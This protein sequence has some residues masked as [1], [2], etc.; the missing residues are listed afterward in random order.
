M[1][2]MPVET[3][4]KATHVKTGNFLAHKDL[5]NYEELTRV[6][7]LAVALGMT[8]IRLTGGEPLVRR[9]VISFIE[10]LAGIDG[11]EQVRLTTNGVLLN[12]YAERLYDA[13]VKHI[14]ISLDTLQRE[15]FNR[16]TGK[17]Y[18]DKVWAGIM[19]A[20]DLGFNVKLNTVAMRNINDDEFKEFGEL[21]LNHP[22]Q[23]RFIEFM[24]VGEKSSWEKKQFIKSDE[25]KEMI[26]SLGTLTPF[27]RKHGEGPARMYDL[28]SNDGRTGS[29][30]F[31]SPISHHFCDKCNRLRLTS[32]GKLRACLL[33]DNETDLKHL[34]RNNGSDDEIIEQIRQTIL[35]KPQGHSLNDDDETDTKQKCNG[36]M[37]RIG[38]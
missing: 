18:F 29:V 21:A 6:V 9:N 11:L 10:K 37:S 15:K 20:S 8:K 26:S 34:L 31:I 30:G 24:P 32:E 23:V 38:G 25:I 13:G 27:E 22:F 17:D 2:C 16:I 19:K 4:N 1:Y 14:N 3:E 7:T 28:E 5:L 33:T 36:R 12:D 35:N